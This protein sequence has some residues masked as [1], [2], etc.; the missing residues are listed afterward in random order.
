M[1]KYSKPSIDIV[2][3]NLSA[4]YMMDAYNSVGDQVQQAPGRKD[5]YVEVEE[6]DFGW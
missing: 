5:S 2:E 6:E 1:K 4:D 3:A